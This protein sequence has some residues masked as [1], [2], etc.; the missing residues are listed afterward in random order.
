LGIDQYSLSVP[1]GLKYPRLFLRDNELRVDAKNGEPYLKVTDLDSNLRV[2]SD[3]ITKWAMDSKEFYF[4][5]PIELKVYGTSGNEIVD[6][7]CGIYSVL[8][9]DVTGL[10]GETRDY[11]IDLS[12]A[13]YARVC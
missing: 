2:V 3:D 13:K 5:R 9:S 12:T 11:I 10:N 6:K 7:K 1:D 4:R 8:A